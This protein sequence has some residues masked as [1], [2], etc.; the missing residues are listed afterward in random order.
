MSIYICPVNKGNWQEAVSITLHQSQEELV[1]S[2]I[3][4]LAY[5][6]I[7]PWDEAFDPYLLYKDD[8]NI[9][10]FYLSYTPNSSDNYWLGGFQLEIYY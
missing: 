6:Y 9:G 2:V 8:K 3:E 4:S 7:K 10:F 1:P 5:A